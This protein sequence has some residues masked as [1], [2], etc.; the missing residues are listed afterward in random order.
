M[1]DLVVPSPEPEIH[2][3][4]ALYG[5]PDSGIKTSP[6]CV[7]LTDI[8]KWFREEI[9]PKTALRKPLKAE[10]GKVYICK[11]HTAHHNITKQRVKNKEEWKDAINTMK[12][13]N[14]DY[15]NRHGTYGNISL[16]ILNQLR[17]LDYVIFS[18]ACLDHLIR[19]ETIGKIYFALARYKDIK[20]RGYIQ[21]TKTIYIKALSR[22]E[23]ILENYDCSHFYSSHHSC[24]HCTKYGYVVLF[25]TLL[26]RLKDLISSIREGYT[27]IGKAYWLVQKISLDIMGKRKLRP[28]HYRETDSEVLAMR[29]ENFYTT[30][31]VDHSNY[32]VI[33][34]SSCTYKVH[35]LV[36]P[37]KLIYTS[38]ILGKKTYKKTVA[39]LVATSPSTN[40]DICHDSLS[41]AKSLSVSRFCRHIFCGDCLNEWNRSNNGNNK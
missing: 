22:L 6:C 27:F 2:K 7:C 5:C 9:L 4:V 25:L 26:D 8:E 3:T 32:S 11:V 23:T 28:S 35:G 38:S 10:N 34:Y 24:E 39:D 30:I 12:L 13:V 18:A 21:L 36:F 1:M 40:C 31:D 19:F 33:P 29:G 37:L 20:N 14:T 41:N 15:K 17:S 16:A